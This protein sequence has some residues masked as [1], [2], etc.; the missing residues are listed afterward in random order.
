M[1]EVKQNMDLMIE[2]LVCSEMRQA[3]ENQGA[4]VTFVEPQRLQ[5]GE[6]AQGAK[7]R[8]LPFP[9]HASPGPASSK[10]GEKHR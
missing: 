3:L 2:L 9:S 10:N 5:C 7:V 1:G 4:F 8:V 6:E